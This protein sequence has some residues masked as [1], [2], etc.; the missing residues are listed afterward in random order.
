MLDVRSALADALKGPEPLRASLPKRVGAE[1]RDPDKVIRFQY[2]EPKWVHH[3]G[4]DGSYRYT[5]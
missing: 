4:K 5:L 1:K 2:Q 3:I